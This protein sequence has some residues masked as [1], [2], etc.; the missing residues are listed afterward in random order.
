MDHHSDM[1]KKKF[2]E[3]QNT[4]PAHFL[5]RGMESKWTKLQITE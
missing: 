5:T 2:L 1:N 3:S 4:A